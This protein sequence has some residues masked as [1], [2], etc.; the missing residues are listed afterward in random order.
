M[1]Y[2]RRSVNVAASAL[3]TE[4]LTQPRP[5]QSLLSSFKMYS[6]FCLYFLSR[7][8]FNTSAALSLVCFK[9]FI[10]DFAGVVAVLG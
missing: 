9:A 7:S 1:L 4:Y 6:S 8:A 5:N 10:P 3:K 2:K